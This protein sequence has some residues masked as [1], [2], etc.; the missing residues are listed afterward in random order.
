M[1]RGA[2]NGV[3]VTQ[4]PWGGGGCWCFYQNIGL[5][6]KTRYVNNTN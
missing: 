1:P 3:T 2:D 6:A 5:E 4:R